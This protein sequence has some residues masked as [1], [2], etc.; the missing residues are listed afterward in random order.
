MPK[1]TYKI[2]NFH[3]GLNNNADPRDIKDEQFPESENVKITK[4][5]QIKKT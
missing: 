2:E 1:Q 4:F 5:G 3:G